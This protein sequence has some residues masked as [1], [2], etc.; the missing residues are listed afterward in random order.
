MQCVNIG[1][2]NSA[3]C[4]GNFQERLEN[5]MNL[6]CVCI[7]FHPFAGSL[8]CLFVHTGLSLLLLAVGAVQEDPG[9]H[10]HGPDPL[11]GEQRVAEHEDAAQDGEELPGGGDDGAR[12]RAKLTHTHEDEELKKDIYFRFLTLRF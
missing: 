3:R 2:I 10:E 4:K 1:K 12:Q 9:K 11:V 5:K 8:Q 7:L 6:V